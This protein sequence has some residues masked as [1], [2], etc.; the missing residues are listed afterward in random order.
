MQPAFPRDKFILFFTFKFSCFIDMLR[1]MMV[2]KFAE[3][4]TNLRMQQEQAYLHFVDFMDE[5]SGKVVGANT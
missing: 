3:K 4:G 2:L 5:C 1:G